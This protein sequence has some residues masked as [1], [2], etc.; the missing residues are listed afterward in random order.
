MKIV[1]D[2]TLRHA[3]CIGTRADITCVPGGGLGDIL[4]DISDDPSIKD[5]QQ[6]ILMGGINDVHNVKDLPDARDFAHAVT[7][8]AKKL[9]D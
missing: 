2:S 7:S 5:Y 3:D 8:A 1:T 9:D 6:I 4:N